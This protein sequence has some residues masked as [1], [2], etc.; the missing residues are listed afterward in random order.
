MSR[1]RA[2]PLG[3]STV[4]SLHLACELGRPCLGD[5]PPSE[6]DPCCVG[7]T[8]EWA[9]LDRT[10]Y[11][12]TPWRIEGCGEFSGPTPTTHEGVCTNQLPACGED[13]GVDAEAIRAAVDHPDVR[14]ALAETPPLFGHDD[15]GADGETILSVTVDGKSLWVGRPCDGTVRCDPIPAGVQQL[16]D[17]LRAATAQQ[18]TIDA[19]RESV[20]ALPPAQDGPCEARMLGYTFDPATG[21]CQ[22]FVY[23]GCGGN[24]NNFRSPLDCIA[25]C[26]PTPIPISAVVEARSCE[27]LGTQVSVAGDET[28]FT[29]AGDVIEK[30]LQW[31]CG[32]REAPEF[33]LAFTWSANP[34][35]IE[36]RLCHD[37]AA[38][39][40][41]AGCQEGVTFDLGPAL[42]LTRADDF[43]F[44]DP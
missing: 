21:T 24:A 26:E 19:C 41:E 3:V 39:P 4:L 28:T 13:A 29:R 22:D 37:E 10:G 7:A 14:A 6:G 2:T 34:S 30:E 27:G 1:F 16:A 38:D 18:T 20:C 44:V 42:W 43:V 15:R 25:M 8:V 17:V 32:C 40:C 33:V 9:E 12:P 23:G 11:R 35:V 36:L 5:C 31:G